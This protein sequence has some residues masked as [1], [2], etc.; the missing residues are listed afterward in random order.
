MP[1]PKTESELAAAGYRFDRVER[2]KGRNCG[3]LL[4][5]YF[6]PKG[7]RIPLEE[8]TLEVHFPKCPDVEQ[9]RGGKQ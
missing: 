4:A 2:C 9:F 5:F 7:K 6:T 8:G 1:F 3:V